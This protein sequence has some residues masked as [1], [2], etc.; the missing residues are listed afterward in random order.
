MDNEITF[1]P[2]HILAQDFSGLPAVVDIASLCASFEHRGKD[3]KKIHPFIPV[4]LMVDYSVQV[5]FFRTKFTCKKPVL[6]NLW[7]V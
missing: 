4:G 6:V 7:T 2:A 5:E 1:K 3:P